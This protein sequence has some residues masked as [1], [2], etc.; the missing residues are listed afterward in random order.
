MKSGIPIIRGDGITCDNCGLCCD[1][2]ALLPLSGAIVDGRALPPEIEVELRQM[3][4][5]NRRT[6]SE[7]CVWL[8]KDGRCTHYDLRP[9]TCRDFEVGGEGCLDVRELRAGDGP[10]L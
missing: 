2:Q 5:D 3:L 9:S 1:G 7:P 10:T 4:R 6:S 8:D